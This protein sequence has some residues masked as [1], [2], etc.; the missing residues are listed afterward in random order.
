M[1]VATALAA[2]GTAL[3]DDPWLDAWPV[4][5]SRVVPVPGAATLE[6]LAGAGAPRGGQR[7]G[8]ADPTGSADRAGDGGWQLADAGGEL[9]LPIDPRCASNLWQL[10]AISGGAPLTV[11]GECGHRGFVPLTAWNGAPV[12]LTSGTSRTG[13]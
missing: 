3:R 5:L 4:V 1:D 9:A 8:G 6:A 2:Y 7:G 12:A 10:T 11:F 13:P